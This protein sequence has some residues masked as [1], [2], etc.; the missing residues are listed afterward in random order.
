MSRVKNLLI[1]GL[2]GVIAVVML[3]EFGGHIKLAAVLLL[4]WLSHLTASDWANYVTI[5]Y[6]V[7][8]IFCLGIDQ[9]KKH[10]NAA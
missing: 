6:G 10:K 2:L 9:Y 5:A 7:A 3:R 4:A 8:Q 1:V